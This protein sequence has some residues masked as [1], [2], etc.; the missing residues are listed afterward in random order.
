MPVEFP[1]AS[2]APWPPAGGIPRLVTDKD[3]WADLAKEAKRNALDLIEFNFQSRTPET[4][5]WY[6]RHK[7][8][9]TLTTADGKNYRFGVK[10]GDPPR[11]FTVYFPP[12]GWHPNTLDDNDEAA[13]KIVLRTLLGATAQKVHFSLSGARVWPGDMSAIAS[14]IMQ[15]KI[16]VRFD[17]TIAPRARYRPRGVDAN[18]MALGSLASGSAER[19]LI[20]H[21]AVHAMQDVRSEGFNIRRAETMAHVAQCLYLLHEGHSSPPVGTIFQKAWLA[22]TNIFYS[23]SASDEDASDVYDA[24]GRDPVYSG[25][26]DP[27]FNGL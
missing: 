2:I 8:G 23:G 18:S 14:Y 26:P 6:L 17:K 22:A 27:G 11:T 1:P 4:I 16:R 15:N 7:V 21:E 3:N 20:V 10:A 13:R 12:S 19:A 24:V 5:N 25:R 9:C